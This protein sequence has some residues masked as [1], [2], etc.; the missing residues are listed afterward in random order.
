MLKAAATMLDG[1]TCIVLGLNRL[2]TER[3]LGSK[4]I[5]VDLREYGIDI[6]VLVMGGETE[7]AMLA[8]IRSYGISLPD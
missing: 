6:N 1:R 2:N 5:M 7:A 4:Y 3:L 8:E